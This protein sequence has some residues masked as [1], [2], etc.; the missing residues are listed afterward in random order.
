MASV[1]NSSR[2]QGGLFGSP[3]LIWDGLSGSRVVEVETMW[4]CFEECWEE[5]EGKWSPFF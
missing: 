2:Q 5:L 1:G 4:F 3:E